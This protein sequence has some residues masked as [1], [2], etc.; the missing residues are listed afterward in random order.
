MHALEMKA[1]D[2]ASP[3]IGMTPR[4]ASAAHEIGYPSSELTLC[5]H[6]AKH[7]L[8]EDARP[9]RKIYSTRKAPQGKFP[10]VLSALR[11]LADR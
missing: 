9:V 8:Y 5:F 6:G 1:S 10:A 2:R 7:E 4:Y 3:A 11:A